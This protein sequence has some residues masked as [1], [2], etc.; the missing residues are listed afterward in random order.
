MI[1]WKLELSEYEGGP[2]IDADVGG[3]PTITIIRLDNSEVIVTDEPMIRTSLG[4]YEYDQTT[5][6]AGL[7][8][9]GTWTVTADDNTGSGYFDKVAPSAACIYCTYIDMVSRFGNKNM[10]LVSDLDN[11][12]NVDFGRVQMAMDFSVAEIHK[13]LRGGPYAIP[14]D[15]TPNGGALDASV[16]EWSMVITYSW[17]YYSRWEDDLNLTES[18]AILKNQTAR[19]VSRL[20]AQVYKDMALAK[21]GITQIPAAAN[22][23]FDASP[24]LITAQDIVDAAADVWSGMY[25]WPD[26]QAVFH[27]W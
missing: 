14:L 9:R 19:M 20:Q 23:G 27:S 26:Q 16:K 25:R 15:W 5:Y 1:P 3:E 17:L 7:T 21:T 24:V 12:K 4:V 18:E 11:T 22:T 13:Q 8:Y 10:L 6:I 2:L